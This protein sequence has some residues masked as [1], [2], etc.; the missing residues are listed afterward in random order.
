MTYLLDQ[1]LDDAASER[2]DHPAVRCAGRELTYGE[3]ADA[4]NGVACALL[5]AG[6]QQGDR[7]GI[8]LPKRIE[9]IVAVYGALRAGAA[10]VPLDPKAPSSRLA[11]VAKD[12][13]IA[14]LVTTP[15]RAGALLP[16]LAGSPPSLVIL[17][18][19]GS[20]GSDVSSSAVDFEAVARRAKD[21]GVNTI[22]TDVA[23]ILYTSGSTGVPKGVTLTHRNA[24]TFVEWCASRIGVRPGDQLSNHAPLH[25]DLSVFDLFLAALGKA[26]V[27]LVPDEIAFF[28]AELVRFARTERIT[29]WYSVPSALTLMARNMKSP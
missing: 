16:S 18:D 4:A 2:P 24:L 26:T 9:T 13:S 11:M 5:E 3:L 28:G 8:L 22:D 15:S 25:F 1:L 6:L 21:P 17:V 10:Y 14:A 20:P 23:Y 12:C 29:T 27:V 7:V 19:D